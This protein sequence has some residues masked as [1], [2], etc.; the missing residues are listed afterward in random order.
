MPSDQIAQ[1]IF[2]STKNSRNLLEV[3][4]ILIVFAH[5]GKKSVINK[6]ETEKTKIDKTHAK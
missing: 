2:L 1:C 3:P 6:T 4:K 5:R